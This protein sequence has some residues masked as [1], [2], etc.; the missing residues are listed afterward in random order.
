MKTLETEMN[1]PEFWKDQF[2]AKEVSQKLDDL[3][4]EVATWEKLRQEAEELL[5]IAQLDQADQ[6]VNLRKEAEVKLQELQKQYEQLEFFT[7]LNEEYDRND[8]IFSIHAGTG[9]VD[10][11]DWAAMLLRMYLRFCEKK[12]FKTKIVQESRGQ[13]AGIKSVTALVQGAW[14]YGYLKAEAGVH[15]LVR[16]SPFDAEKM[17]HTSFALLEVLPDLGDL[18][19]IELKEEDLKIDTFR[20][21]GHGGQSV[22]TTDSA[23]RITHQPT[24]ITVSCQ[25]ERSQLQNKEFALKILKSKLHQLMLSQR[26]EKQNQLRG[27]AISA[28]WGNQIRSY[29]LHPYKM[30]KDHRTKYEVKNPEKVLNGEIDEFIEAF[31]KKGIRK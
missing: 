31:L 2:R 4:K 30:V 20:S 9:G 26:K 12:G 27:E 25:N 14:A 21:S 6:D 11:Q 10:A 3:K 24:G 16:I 7:L 17:R 1:Q 19:G 13:E 28:E 8:A 29:V 22:N 15:R 18:K 23:V 5:E